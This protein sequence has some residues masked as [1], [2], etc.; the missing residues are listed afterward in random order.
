MSVPA[1]N[2][3]INYGIRPDSLWII[4]SRS[5][6]I[7]TW[8]ESDS[9][10]IL[11]YE[12]NPVIESRTGFVETQNRDSTLLYHIWVHQYPKPLYIK[13][14]P[15]VVYVEADSSFISI[16]I[17]APV[18]W[19][20]NSLVDW[21]LPLPYNDSIMYV[22]YKTNERYHMRQGNIIISLNDTLIKE[23]QFFQQ[24]STVGISSERNKEALEIF[25]NPARSKVNVRMAST[26]TS[27]LT[28]DIF[29]ISGENVLNKKIPFSGKQAELDISQLGKGIYFMKL[30]GSQKNFV[31]KLIIQ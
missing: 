10:F 4:T 7:E 27:I 1:D 19:S 20:A 30:T 9:V 31:R 13:V 28:I 6:W 14:D 16:A 23:I 26:G 22:I 12:A 21:L 29:N 5:A 18:S 17:D 8:K 3:I 15:A 25:P 2:G 11:K 24:A